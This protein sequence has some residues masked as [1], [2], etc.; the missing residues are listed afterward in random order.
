MT[1]NLTLSHAPDSPMGVVSPAKNHLEWDTKNRFTNKKAA[2]TIAIS[3]KA[4]PTLD[5]VRE[6][7]GIDK[8]EWIACYTEHFYK[9]AELIFAR[10]S[11]I[12][13]DE[14]CP[15]M[16][17]GPNYSYKFLGNSYKKPTLLPANKYIS[18]L[19]IWI[20]SQLSDSTLFPTEEGASYP[21]NFLPVVH[22]IFKRLFRVY[23]HIYWSHLDA[24]KAQG[25]EE[26]LN[27]L[28]THMTLFI[29]EFNLVSMSEMKPLEI[30]VQTIAKSQMKTTGKP[31]TEE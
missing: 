27:Q 7:T 15:V 6:P 30:R 3:V 18:E 23:A 14:S 29:L 1:T 2:A 16:K 31:S 12:C 24:I 22:D 21:Q 9:A 11:I 4:D 26:L 8:N 5:S 10:I 13:T 19:F 20:N 17:A 25:G 28:F